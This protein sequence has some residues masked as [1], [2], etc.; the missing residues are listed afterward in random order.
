MNIQYFQP[1]S[2]GF[3]RMKKALFQPFDLKKWFVVGF[4]AWLA[5]LLDGGGSGGNNAE[6]FNGNFGDALDAPYDA[7]YWLQD[8]PQWIAAVIFGAAFLLFLLVVLTWLSSRGKFMFV[9]NIVHDRALISQPWHDYSKM[10]DS[11]FI[12]RLIFSFFGIAAVVGF[13]VKAWQNLH[14]LYFGP[15]DESIPWAFLVKTI[16]LF[17]LLITVI[18]YIE[19]LLNEFVVAIMYKNRISATQAWQRLLSIHGAHF[20]QFFLFAILWTLL[21]VAVVIIVVVGG[22]MTCCIGFLLLLIPVI[23]AVITLPISYTMRS[24]SLEFISQFGDEFSVFS[25][26]Q[27]SHHPNAVG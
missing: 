21:V 3:E 6:K 10:G 16:L 13:L 8:N 9:D 22:L 19:L 27:G 25:E 18:G 5:G 15:F 14:S 17:I 24:F 4:T 26:G 11:L 2:L 1:L 23:N 20:G 7:W 12:W